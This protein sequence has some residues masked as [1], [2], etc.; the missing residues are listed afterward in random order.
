MQLV[1]GLD[2]VTCLCCRRR[3]RRRD[4]PKAH[5]P[6]GAYVCDGRRAR[7][8]RTGRRCVVWAAAVRG[9][10]AAGPFADRRALGHT[11][12]AAGASGPP[13]GGAA[14]R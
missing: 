10:Q 7:W 6:G 12:A 8:E 3:V 2:T 4:A 11:T 13:D 14:G 5:G 9:I 1:L